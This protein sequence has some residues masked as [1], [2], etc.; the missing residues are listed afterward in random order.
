VSGVP[1]LVER[2][3][4][5]ATVTAIADEAAS[6]T[7]RVLLIEGPAGIGK[8]RLLE[9]L[10]GHAQRAGTLTLTAR[11]GELERD[12]PFGV[13]RQLLEGTVGGPRAQ[14]QLTD[15]AAPARA[16]FALPDD[17]D[18]AA[19]A[20]FA[21]LHGLFWLV[22]DLAAARPVMLCVDDLH[23]CDAASLRFLG[24]LARR[25]EDQP[26]LLAAT[27]RTAEPGVDAALM[28]DVIH[29]PGAA[30]VQPGPFSPAA[31]RALATARLGADPDPAFAAAC[32]QA[33]GGN[34]L[35][36]GQ[37]LAALEAEHVVPDAAHVGVVRDIGPRAVSRTVLLRLARLPEEAREVA[38]AVAVL[39]EGADL[40]TTAALAGLDEPRAADA[41]RALARAELLLP[42]SPLRFTH[43]LV[44]AAVYND[45]GPGRRELEHA[46]AADVLRERGAPADQIATHLLAMPRRGDA[47]VARRLQD[48]GRAAMRRGAVD[49]A[50]SLLGRALAEPPAED[51]RPTL[52]FELGIAEGLVS[53]GEAEQHLRDAYA[54]LRDPVIRAMAAYQ[55]ARA[56]IFLGRTEEAQRLAQTAQRDLEESP[57]PQLADLRHALMAIEAMAIFFGAAGAA[58]GERLAAFAGEARG[59]GPGGRM[60]AAVLAYDDMRHGR[61]A[62]RAIAMAQEALADGILLDAENG[63]VS[64]AAILTL[65]AA[66]REEAVDALEAGTADAHR[67]GSPFAALAAHIWGGYLQLQRGDLPGARA[68]CS[69]SA[70][71]ALTYGIVEPGKSYSNVW[72][73]RIAQ[74]A[75][76]LDAARELLTGDEPPRVVAEI[77]HLW[78]RVWIDQLLLDGRAE[79]ALAAC[80]EY[81]AQVRELDN[82]VWAPW[83]SARGRALHG[84]GRTQEAIGLL[85]EELS[86]A[87]AWGA[88][89]GIGRALRILGALRG[90]AGIAE[91][92]EAV[93]VLEPS[94]ARLELA[95]ALAALGAALRRGRE[96]TEAREPLRR[97]LELAAACGAEGLVAEVRGELQATGLRPRTS[98]LGGVNSLTASERRVA[99][100]AAA[101]R[102]NREIAQALYVT[103]KTVEVHLS[104]AYRKLGISSR[105]GLAQALTPATA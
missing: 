74:E 61:A 49:S 20:S 59:P 87:R 65:I 88:P 38:R 26:V 3:R 105:H 98:A 32:L 28:A 66:D 101:G 77:R 80:D 60:L 40:P 12:F 34:P 33:T 96:P 55:L 53:V 90:A 82:P 51:D 25:L 104:N 16:V 99:D 37:L 13:V 95:R 97:A 48:A 73:A 5:L 84:L 42:E 36:L 2:E 39:G 30:A 17:G 62:G 67:R 50:V 31:V 56:R 10:R 93:A 7:G 86:R 47:D 57:D 76:D 43:P 71:E 46:R 15:A 63:F 92:R 21:I 9:E 89:T 69:Q 94:P 52:L 22:L 54:G 102:S 83:R 29:A 78:L 64:V 19:G 58:A 72:L 68:L 4:E 75:G 45:L 91:L 100:L 8:S 41:V 24:Y 44:R 1:G 79:E 6:G 85:E 81:E 70:Q 27:L 35:L 103:P 14:V 18:P 11:G 23:W